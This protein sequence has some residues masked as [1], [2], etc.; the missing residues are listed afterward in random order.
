M[1]WVACEAET[2]KST[3]LPAFWTPATGP[4][5]LP[6]APIKSSIGRRPATSWTATR[7]PAT[8]KTRSAG[9]PTPQSL[10][11]LAELGAAE[12]VADGVAGGHRP[13][14]ERPGGGTPDVGA[15]DT[16][17][18]RDNSQPHEHREY[19]AAE[20]EGEHRLQGGGE[21]QGSQQEI[22]DRGQA[23]SEIGDG[24]CAGQDRSDRLRKTLGGP[25]H[26]LGT[27]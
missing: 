9:L 6:S 27:S 22:G 3:R 17:L 16:D 18:G 8:S 23:Q 2:M 14:S 1:C 19:L 5:L 15:G 10:G 25:R 12:L 4:P 26:Q 11:T 20:T 13:R 21:R 7:P 24:G